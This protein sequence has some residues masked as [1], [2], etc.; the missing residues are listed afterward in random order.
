VSYALAVD[1]AVIARPAHTAV[2]LRVWGEKDD[3]TDYRQRDNDRPEPAL[4]LSNCPKHNLIHY[5]NY[6]ANL[7]PRYRSNAK[8]GHP[9]RRGAQ[10]LSCRDFPL[11]RGLEKTPRNAG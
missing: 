5:K 6:Q 9:E 10:P 4:V 2:H 3:K 1:G 7:V 8:T 11:G